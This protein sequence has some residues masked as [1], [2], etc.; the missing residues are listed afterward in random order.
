[1]EL[2]KNKFKRT[3]VGLIPEDWD[4]LRIGSFANCTSGGTPSTQNGKYWG[5]DIPWMNSGELNLKHVYDVENR[6]TE[7]GLNNSSTKYIPENSVLIGLAGQGKTRGTVAIN[8]VRLCIN[9]SIASIFP[10]NKHNSHFLYFY[11]DSQYYELRKLSTGDGGRGGLNLGIIKSLFVPIATLTEQKAIATALSDV[12]ELIAKL[13]KLIEKKKA[14]KQGAMQALLTPKKDWTHAKIFELGL[15]ISDGNYSSKYPKSSEFKEIGIPFI[16]A[17]NIKDITILD[18][19]MRYI[20]SE[21]HAELR[22]GHLKKGD[23]LITTRGEIGQIAIVPD[24]FVN[25]NINAQIVRI[26]TNDKINNYF[27]AYSLMKSETQSTLLNLQTG[28]ALKQLPV[29]KLNQVKISFPRREEQ[30]SIANILKVIDSDIVSLDTK[31]QKYKN[32]K[33]GMMQELL[34]GRTRLV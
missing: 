29:G 26:N 12:D 33:Q 27:F 30:D 14:I 28:S 5:G 22:K 20:S 13:E 31:C 7:D 11:L 19:D 21:L 18:S 2:T 10:S 24:R 23:I 1:M 16:R 6:I 15:D 17:N 25:S 34:T 3:E 8:H 9:Q 4:C 32:V